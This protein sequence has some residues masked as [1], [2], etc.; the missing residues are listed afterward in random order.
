MGLHPIS[1]R[2][3]E[4]P[5]SLTFL[6]LAISY[7]LWA[8]HRCL[9]DDQSRYNA[10]VGEVS[11]LIQRK[12]SPN[13]QD[14]VTQSIC[15]STAFPAGMMCFREVKAQSSIQRNLPSYIHPA[16][17]HSMAGRYLLLL[18]AMHVAKNCPS[19]FEKCS[20]SHRKPSICNDSNK[21]NNK[22]P[23]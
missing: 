20:S 6:C 5:S 13:K 4:D 18:S 2:R 8:G 1:R 19:L 16:L 3:G 15:H 10:S 17:G 11:S 22:N 7:L 12:P 14:L 9:K 21:N 23:P